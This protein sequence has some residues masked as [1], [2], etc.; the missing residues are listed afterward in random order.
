MTLEHIR[1]FDAYRRAPKPLETRLQEA[2][3]F[4]RFYVLELAL[5]RI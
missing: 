4:G 1:K 5:F 3:C 2:H